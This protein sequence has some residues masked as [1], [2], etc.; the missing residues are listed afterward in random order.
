MQEYYWVGFWEKSIMK[1]RHAMFLISA[2]CLLLAC[3][4]KVDNPVEY[5]K[6]TTESFC[7]TDTSYFDYARG[8]ENA[9]KK[10]QHL[11]NIKW[12]PKGNIPKWK[13]SGNGFF[14]A[15]QTY[16]GVPHSSVKEVNTYL[17]RDVSLY[18]FMTAVNNPKS[19]LYTD[20]LSKPPYHGVGCATYYGTTCSQAVNY[21][22]G[23]EG[24]Y[25]CKDYPKV[26]F[27][28]VETQNIDSVR[29]CD[30][31]WRSGHVMM[32]YNIERNRQNDFV[33]S[34][35][36]LEV[37]SLR[38]YTR[39]EF[40]SLWAEGKYVIMRYEYLGGN[41][42]YEP[43]PFVQIGDE[44][45]VTVSFNNDL[46]PDKGDKSCYRT[47]EPVIINVMNPMLTQVVVEDAS[48]KKVCEKSIIEG[49]CQINDLTPGLYHAKATDGIICSD[50]VYFEVIDAY[51]TAQITGTKIEVSF[52]SNNAIPKYL[53]VCNEAG[54]GY[55]NKT[56]SETE[57]KNGKVIINRPEVSSYFIKVSFKGEYGMV[58]NE[59]LLVN[60]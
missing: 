37:S 20:D 17:C 18:T 25:A 42:K 29:L 31:L 6:F 46:C 56:L 60:M 35:T 13:Q 10:T 58:I 39:D 33:E 22:L 32:I 19:R 47:G 59:P 45:A 23:L 34:V 7:I 9:L 12:V 30:V 43:T 26:G 40:L 24:P 8:V 5:E 11:T 50:N 44:E 53:A 52:H 28:R 21:V 38:K 41:L 48:G 57:I 54:S 49:S 4:D 3:D 27:Y 15:G 1:I 14:Y 2:L 36:L 51:V 16:K 55:G